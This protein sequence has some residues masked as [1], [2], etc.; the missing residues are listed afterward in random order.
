MHVR[1]MQAHTHRHMR[2][3]KRI[4]HA[5]NPVYKS[6]SVYVMTEVLTPHVRTCSCSAGV[7]FLLPPSEAAGLA[8]A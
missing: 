2:V 1:V 6:S 3:S 5:H 4:T 8:V 7:S